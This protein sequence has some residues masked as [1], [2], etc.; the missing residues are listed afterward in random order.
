MASF[1]E[2]LE[3][4]PRASDFVIRAAYRCLVQHHHP[5]KNPRAEGA[6]QRLVL[7]NK[8]LR[9]TIRRRQTNVL[10]PWPGAH[11]RWR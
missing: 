4:S 9:R 1:Y 7:I 2:T 11:R 8:S 3:V 6:G 5:D 10:R